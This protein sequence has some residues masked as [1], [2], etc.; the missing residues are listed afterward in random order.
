TILPI[1]TPE[2][3][4]PVALATPVA[5]GLGIRVV[6]PIRTPER[7]APVALAT[8]VALGLG[9]RANATKIEMH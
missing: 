1:R 6:L 8:P 4:A 2:R 7:A 9:I 3:A 5:L